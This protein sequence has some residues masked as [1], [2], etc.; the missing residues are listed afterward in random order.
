MVSRYE[1]SPVHIWK[2]HPQAL[3]LSK[4]GKHVFP[5]LK[6]YLGIAKGQKIAIFRMPPMEP[7]KVY[8]NAPTAALL[9]Y[10]S[11]V[12]F[13]DSVCLNQP[14]IK[15]ESLFS[16][17]LVVPSTPDEPG[18]CTRSK[19]ENQ[20]PHFPVERKAISCQHNYD[21]PSRI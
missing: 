1:L 19:L 2:E 18:Q 4:H 7:R 15:H 20:A 11:L 13:A 17:S 8:R 10:Q 12:A 3:D 16:K 6:A 14:S 21:W 5:Q 9:G